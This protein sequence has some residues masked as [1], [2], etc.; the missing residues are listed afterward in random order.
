MHNQQNRSNSKTINKSMKMKTAMKLLRNLNLMNKISQMIILQILKKHNK[1]KK[2][3][4]LRMCNQSKPMKKQLKNPLL[5]NKKKTVR[6][7]NK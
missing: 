2:I 4:T 1:H 7:K 6:S 5:M 3:K